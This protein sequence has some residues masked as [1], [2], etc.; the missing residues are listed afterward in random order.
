[1]AQSKS[2]AI[3][4]RS[5]A[6]AL[7]PGAAP[8][9]ELIVAGG[10]LP[11][12]LKRAFR[13]LNL[14]SKNGT[15]WMVLACLL[16]VQFFEEGKARGRRAWSAS[17]LHELLFE[18]QQ[19]KHKNPRLSDARICS[20]IAK[21]KNSP[22]HFR[23]GLRGAEGRGQG[24]IKRLREARRYFKNNSLARAVFPLAFGRN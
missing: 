20:L 8:L 9:R 1:M 16:A 6:K 4:R 7:R 14:N 18:V 22:P 2:A 13:E 21:D 12:P 11:E 3:R 19:R 23:I 17:Q 24:L 5:L 15:D 10:S